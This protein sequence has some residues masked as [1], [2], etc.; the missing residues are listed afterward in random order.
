[1]VP[2]DSVE[3]RMWGSDPFPK[4]V[5][6][7]GAFVEGSTIMEFVALTPERLAEIVAR[8]EDT[9]V[10]RPEMLTLAIELDDE[11]QDTLEETS[12]DDPSL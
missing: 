3:V 5:I 2:S 4:T 12:F 8:P 7:E 10:A 11:D 9:A 6:A 1:M